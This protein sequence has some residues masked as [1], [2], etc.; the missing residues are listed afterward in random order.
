[1]LVCVQSTYP[2][3]MH[4]EHTGGDPS[5]CLVQVV[6]KKL[7]G[8]DATF[9]DLAAAFPALARSF[10]AM[11]RMEGNIEDVISRQVERG[12]GRTR[13]SCCRSRTTW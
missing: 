4:W 3:V 10:E 8:V 6:Y 1:V 2:S 11:L 12:L 7:L 9:G 5:A 13:S